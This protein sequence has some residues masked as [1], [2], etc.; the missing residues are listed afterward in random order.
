[1]RNRLNKKFNKSKLEVDRLNRN[2][3]RSQLQKLIRT[4]KREYVTEKLTEN[5]NKPKDL[6]KNIKSLGLPSKSASE[7]KISLKNDNGGISFSPKE[8]A[9]KFKSFYSDLA[10]NLVK[11]LPVVSGRFELDETRLY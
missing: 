11:K 6:W 5:I 2:H 7:S 4:R 3:V 10:A 1:M 8:V 9:N